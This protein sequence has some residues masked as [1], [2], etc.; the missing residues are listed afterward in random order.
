MSV[1]GRKPIRI[2]TADDHP[3]LREGIVATLASEPDMEVVGHASDGAEAVRLYRELEPDIVLMDLR[4]PGVG[5]VEATERIRTMDP[6]ARIIIVT[7]YSGDAQATA[8]LRAG[9]KGYLLKLSLRRELVDAIRSVQA[10][11]RHLQSEIATAI[12]FGATN[13][14]LTGRE[15]RVLQLAADGNSNKQIAR[16]LEISEETVKGHMKT[17]FIKLGVTDRTHAVTCAARRGIIDL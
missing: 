5:G 11:G 8:A 16:Q 1:E 7:T 10:G 9:A 3:L 6:D 13:T 2:L 12:A 15:I 17:I 4:M 14:P